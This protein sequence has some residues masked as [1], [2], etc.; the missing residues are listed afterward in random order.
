MFER[1]WAFIVWFFDFL[2]IILK[3]VPR[4]LLGLRKLIQHTSL[5]KYNEFRKRD[6]IHVFRQNVKRY[7]SKPCF[8]LDEKSLSFQEVCIE[9]QNKNVFVFLC[10]S[11]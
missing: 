8:I 3:T 1:I 11:A 4:D 5:I 9:L 10:V 7:A 6:F 2:L